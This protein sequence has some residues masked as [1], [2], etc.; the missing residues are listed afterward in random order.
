MSKEEINDINNIRK[1]ISTEKQRKKK[2]R[3]NKER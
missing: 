1:Q 2:K 3:K